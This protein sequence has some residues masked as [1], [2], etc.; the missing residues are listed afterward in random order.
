MAQFLDRA[1]DLPTATGDHPFTDIG[2]RPPGVQQAIANLYEAGI[3]GGCTATT[4]CPT[5]SVT[6][7]QMS[8]F[9]VIG[10]GLTPIPGAGSFTDDNGQFSEQYNNR[11]A[12][13]EITSGCGPGLFC[14]QANVLR[15]QMANFLFEA[16]N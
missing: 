10:Y 4:F 13:D 7:G 8:K 11:M 14:P 16:E 12:Q 1:L 3:T 15:E 5:A 2:S 9:I 6:R